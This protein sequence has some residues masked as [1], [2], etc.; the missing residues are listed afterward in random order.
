MLQE[1]WKLR[2]VC[3]ERVSELRGMKFEYSIGRYL[4][5]VSYRVN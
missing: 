4:R 1:D 2:S 3:E 5:P